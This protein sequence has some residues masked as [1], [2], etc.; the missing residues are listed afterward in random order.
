MSSAEPTVSVT[1]NVPASWLNVI[2]ITGE[3]ALSGRDAFWVKQLCAK[4]MIA[5]MERQPKKTLKELPPVES[6]CGCLAD[7]ASDAPDE[8]IPVK[9][10]A[11]LF[12]CTG[13]GNTYVNSNP[14]EIII[15][16]ACHICDGM[17]DFLFVGTFLPSWPWKEM[18]RFRPEPKP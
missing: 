5:A 9:I 17:R 4:I 16:G 14:N 3:D 7:I 11:R 13:C 2:N 18:Q 6:F 12:R 15:A 8:P 1:I 10:G